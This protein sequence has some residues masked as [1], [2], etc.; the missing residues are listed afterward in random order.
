MMVA[1]TMDLGIMNPMNIPDIRYASFVGESYLLLPKLRFPTNG[2]CSIVINTDNEW[3]HGISAM[4][5]FYLENVKELTLENCAYLLLPKI[6]FP[7]EKK[8]SIV[9]DSLFENIKTGMKKPIH[10][11]HVKNCVYL[12]VRGLLYQKSYSLIIARLS[13][14]ILSR[15]RLVEGNTLERLEINSD[16]TI[17][18]S[19]SETR[20]ALKPF[21]SIASV[22]LNKDMMVLADCFDNSEER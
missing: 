22:G 13:T 3:I 1:S 5:E 10:L 2:K 20:E 7:Q 21:R 14:R 6:I 18:L 15:M 8:H 9:V 11:R 19:E 16:F 4:K 17:E 12:E